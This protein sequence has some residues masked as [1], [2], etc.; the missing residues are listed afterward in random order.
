M[1]AIHTTLE[2]SSQRRAPKAAAERRGEAFAAPQRPLAAERPRVLI[3]SASIG[4]GHIRAAE[5]IGLAVR[6]LVPGARVHRVNVLDFATPPRRY[7]YADMYL[8]FIRY[9]HRFIGCI[10][11][12]IDRCRPVR[13]G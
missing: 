6:E 3:L 12:Y 13:A 7:C 5:A 2:R 11:D 8:N 1:T 10:Y 4:T 9:A